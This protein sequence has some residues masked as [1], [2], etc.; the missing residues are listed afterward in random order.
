MKVLV[1]GDSFGLPRCFKNSIEIEVKYEDAYPQKLGNMLK[2]EFKEDDILII[3]RSK[4]YNNSLFILQEDF[5]E[6]YLIQPE[7]LVIQVG[8]VDC[9][10]RNQGEYI[11]Q[12]FKGKNPWINESEYI[13]YIEQFIKK[14]FESISS[15]KSIIVVNITKAEEEQY[16]RH[17]GSYERTIMYNNR[18]ET[19]K[20]I[21]NVYIG[22]VYKI[23]DKQ[24]DTSLSS[25]KVHPSAHGNKLI[26]KEIYNIIVDE[27][28]FNKAMQSFIKN[29]IKNSIYYFRK[30]YDNGIMVNDI[31]WEALNKL[32]ELYLS[33]KNYKELVSILFLKNNNSETYEINKKFKDIVKYVSKILVED[34]DIRFIDIKENYFDLL[35]YLIKVD[36]IGLFNNIVNKFTNKYD[37]CA[38]E[39]HGELMLKYKLED[40]ATESF[41]K[42]VELNSGKSTIYSYIAKKF[43][44]I[45]EIEEALNF[46]LTALNFDKKNMDAYDVAINIYIDI[47]DFKKAD[48]FELLKKQNNY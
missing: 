46:A 9:W 34:I 43:V 20:D 13:K 48:E 37:C 38:Y 7:Y 17:E 31:Y 15:L 45:N 14:C 21:N 2:S 41:I 35:D 10:A 26:A 12:Q 1:L 33:N 47:K 28:Y 6:I 16:N 19:L 25:D 30:V 8:I 11:C 4:R 32:I 27:I 23:F 24:L 18:L 39:K 40:L 36:E 44:E 3:N 22:D 5:K 29:E 42:A